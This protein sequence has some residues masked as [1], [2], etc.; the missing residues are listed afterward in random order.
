MKIRAA[1]ENRTRLS[2]IQVQS[3]GVAKWLELYVEVEVTIGDY[4]DVR[5]YPKC[6]SVCLVRLSWST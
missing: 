2:E 4:V 3:A 1:A 5:V 6:N